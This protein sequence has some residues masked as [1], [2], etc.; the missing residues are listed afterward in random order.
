[1]LTRREFM[2]GLIKEL[3]ECYYRLGRDVL[4]YYG[5]DLEVFAKQQAE[6][7]FVELGESV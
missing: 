4:G 6:E 5:S 7:A 1:M 3:Y 2:D